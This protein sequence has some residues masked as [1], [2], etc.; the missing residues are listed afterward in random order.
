M[1]EMMGQF[2]GFVQVNAEKALL[3]SRETPANSNGQ[4]IS[5]RKK[6]AKHNTKHKCERTVRKSQI[7]VFAVNVE[8]T[9]SRKTRHD[10]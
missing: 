2:C 9:K 5:A 6:K 3:N 7:A 8:G 1:L 10:A 4:R